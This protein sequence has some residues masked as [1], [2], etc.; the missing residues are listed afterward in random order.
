MKII[1][2][3]NW[4]P[5]IINIPIPITDPPVDLHKLLGK[6]YFTWDH[7]LIISTGGFYYRLSGVVL[8]NVL[9]VNDYF[10]EED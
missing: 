3:N 7:T 9:Y 1:N 2:C 5:R 10:D 6:F 8:Y 4:T